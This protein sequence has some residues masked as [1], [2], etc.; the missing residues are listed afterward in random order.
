M[1]IKADEDN[2]DVYLT[3]LEYRNTP[4]SKDL[5]SPAE[6]LMGRK[7]KGLLPIEDEKG[8]YVEVRE[9]LI[10]LQNK[11]KQYYDKNA[12]GLKELKEG[13]KVYLQKERNGKQWSPGVIKNKIDGRRSYIVKLDKGGELWRNRRLLHKTPEVL[14]NKNG[15][16][17]KEN[18][19]VID[20]EGRTE[21][22]RKTKIPGKFKDFKM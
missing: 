7:I 16:K 8:K 1:L 10:E 17:N 2:K 22:K 3:L 6:I 12:K 21:Y 4:I 15:E 5:A 11:Q 18:K 13:D 14:E 9:K 19:N 20:R